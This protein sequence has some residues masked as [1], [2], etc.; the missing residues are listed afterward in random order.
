MC[1]ANFACPG[2]LSCGAY[3]NPGYVLENGECIGTPQRV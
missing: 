2:G 3:C 1:G